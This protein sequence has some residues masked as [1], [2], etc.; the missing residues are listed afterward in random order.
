MQHWM[1]S[2]SYLYVALCFKMAFNGI[3]ISHQQ[4]EIL[5]SLARR[6]LILNRLNGFVYFVL[7]TAF[8]VVFFFCCDVPI[9]DFF[10]CFFSIFMT[11][12]LVFSYKRMMPWLRYLGPRGVLAA[13]K[14]V[15]VQIICLFLLS[16]FDFIADINNVRFAKQCNDGEVDISYAGLITRTLDMMVLLLWRVI[17]FT[18]LIVFLRQARPLYPNEY[19]SIEKD[20]RQA[21]A[22]EDDTMY[23]SNSYDEEDDENSSEGEYDSESDAVPVAEMERLRQQ[24]L[25]PLVRVQLSSDS[26]VSEVRIRLLTH[27]LLSISRGDYLKPRRRH[28]SYSSD[29]I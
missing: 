11:T 26:D 22:I 9:M 14:T 12:I 5:E 18:M 19:R 4:R 10:Y 21:F 7:V 24:R 29:T 1:Y 17:T 28:M 23:V 3:G 13:N 27:L 2:T 20:L 6:E 16:I 8:V 25:R 15:S